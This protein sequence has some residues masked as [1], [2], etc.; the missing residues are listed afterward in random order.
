MTTI[1]CDMKC[2][3]GDSLMNDAGLAATT[4]KVF[5]V[6]NSL[7]GIAGSIAEGL[8][9]VDWYKDRRKKKPQLTEAF[10]ALVL[11]PDG[12]EA[13][14]DNLIPIPIESFYYAI[15]SGRDYAMTS[16]YYGKS[17]LDAAMVA[18]E[19]DVSSNTPVIYEVLVKTDKP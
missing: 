2:M 5:R 18:C 12:I 19:F 17:V 14:E 7:I 4:K 16:M 6:G 10:Q 11:T 9:F 3:A 1:V 13:W 8:E 15:G